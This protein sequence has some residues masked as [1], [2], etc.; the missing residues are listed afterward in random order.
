MVN[1]LIEK[2]SRVFKNLELKLESPQSE[3]VVHAVLIN[4]K[5]F[6]AIFVISAPFLSKTPVGMLY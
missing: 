6:Y 2:R 1:F 5:L 4:N 3:T